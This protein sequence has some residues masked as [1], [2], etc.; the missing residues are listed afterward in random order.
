MD[1]LLELFW[2]FLKVNLLST[3]GPASIGLLYHEV[4]GKMV[5]EG[6]FVQAVGLSSVLPGSDAL[7]M[8][9]YVGYA[10]AGIPGGFIAL[11]GSILPPTI[12]IL[13]VT[14]I[15]HRLRRE[16]WLSNFIEGLTPAISVLMLFVAAKIFQ[17]GGA[18]GWESWALGIVSLLVMFYNAPAR[19]VVLVAGVIGV[20][21][22]K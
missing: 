10:V 20:F 7:Q 19:I 6:Q 17:Q 4:V 21:L 3:S 16:A 8:A 5:T 22:F 12:I 1:Q 9:M 14:M 18:I 15:L 11:I 2:I 13:G